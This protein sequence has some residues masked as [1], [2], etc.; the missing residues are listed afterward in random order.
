M[1]KQF[2]RPIMRSK[3]FVPLFSL[4]LGVVVLAAMWLGGNPGAGLVSLAIM[5]AFGLFIISRPW[6]SS[7]GEAKACAASLD[8]EPGQR[9]GRVGE[10]LEDEAAHDAIVNGAPDSALASLGAG[11][12]RR[13]CARWRADRSHCSGVPAP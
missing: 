9:T 11:S 1:I 3:W 5:A 6:P 10:M 13:T 4:G 2:N 7:A 8:R 12:T